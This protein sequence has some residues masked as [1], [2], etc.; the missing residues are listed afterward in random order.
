[1]VKSQTTIWDSEE[2]KVH[3]KRSS[4]GR[5]GIGITSSSK[6][7]ISKRKLNGF[8]EDLDGILQGYPKIENRCL[9]KVNKDKL[10]NSIPLQPGFNP[11]IYKKNVNSGLS[12]LFF[13]YLCRQIIG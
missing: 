11:S 2:V 10:I 7:Y 8:I 9:V 1:M 5:E 6:T 13:A 3:T 12:F 4:A